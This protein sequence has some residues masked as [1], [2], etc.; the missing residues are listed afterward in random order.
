[1]VLTTIIVIY[2]LM[3]EPSIGISLIC[4]LPI[5]IVPI[6]FSLGVSYNAYI[7]AKKVNKENG[8]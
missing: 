7:G 2:L 1:M 4:C 3:A 6:I 5:F 8:F